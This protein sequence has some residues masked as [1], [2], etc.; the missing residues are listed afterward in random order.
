VPARLGDLPAAT[1]SEILRAVDLLVSVSGFALISEGEAQDREMH[2]HNLALRPLGP[3]AEMR[4]QAL[5]RVLRGLEGMADL[6]FDARH[7]RLGTYAIHL[8]TGRV[9]RDGEP[10]AIDV[11]KRA[12]PVAVPSLPYDEKLL[13]AICCAA[14]EIARREETG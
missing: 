8:A 12:N 6:H 5:K 11:P 4:K 7:L 2:L 13:E 1:L 3:M 9:T 14:I 10:I